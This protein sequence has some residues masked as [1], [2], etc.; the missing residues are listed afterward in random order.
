MMECKNSALCIFD[1]VPVQTDIM[2]SYVE[3]YYPISGLNG[4]IEFAI[5]GNT[6]DYID[7]NDIYLYAQYRILKADGTKPTAGTDKVATI[8]LPLASLFKDVSLVVGAEQIEG[9]QQS[10]PYLAY[11]P[12]LLQMH[13]AAQK[14]HMFSFGWA[15]DQA[16]KLD[17]AS[18]TGFVKRQKWV[19]GGRTHEVYGPLFLDFLRQSRYLISQVDM[20][21]KLTPHKPE[22]ALLSFDTGPNYKIKFEKCILNVRRLRMNPSVINGHTHGMVKR[23]AI[24]PIN[25]CKLI[26]F[27][28]PAGQRS[29]TRERLFPLQAP[30]MLAIGLVE[31]DA[32]N[33]AYNK[34]P[35][36]LQHFNLSE[37]MLYRNGV[38][39]PGRP[40]TPDFSSAGAGSSTQYLRSYINTMQTMGYFNSDDSN[41]L[42]YE[43]FGG[44]FALFAFD[45]TADNNV[46]APYRQ[47]VSNTNLRIDLK[48][49]KNLPATINLL[50]Y[51]VFDSQVEIT[52]TR[53]VL[54][55]YSR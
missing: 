22:F 37:I 8:N 32:Y 42:T 16:G 17:D 4:P 35:F 47:V 15:R 52:Q 55:D 2:R 34:N 40:F 14:S 6:E 29:Y 36:N 45:L 23:N 28:I 44:G 26:D 33:G 3:P 13:P 20:R 53:D 54:T 18:N 10:Y 39:V 5:E 21:I 48:F 24:Y 31:N 9:G 1:G 11:F 49:A 51:A 27:T 50:I 46:S 25:H 41:G 19:D 43:E 12:T 7:S 38:G 30:K